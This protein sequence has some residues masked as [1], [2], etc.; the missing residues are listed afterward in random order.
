MQMYDKD[1]KVEIQC[2]QTHGV[3]ETNST[4]ILKGQLEPVT[5]YLTYIVSRRPEKR[6]PVDQ[7]SSHDRVECPADQIWH[8]LE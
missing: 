1:Q 5:R 6:E 2:V 4:T 3:H 8:T 7:L